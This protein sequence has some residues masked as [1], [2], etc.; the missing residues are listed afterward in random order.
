[1]GLK[2]QMDWPVYNIYDVCTISWYR[3][4]VKKK[5][6]RENNRMFFCTSVATFRLGN[7]TYLYSL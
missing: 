7:T 1:M 5:D 2:L 6:V 4:W 3:K